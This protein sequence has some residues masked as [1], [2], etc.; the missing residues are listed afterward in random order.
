[1]STLTISMPEGLAK[2][3]R[4]CAAEEGVTVDPLPTPSSLLLA[5][6]AEHGIAARASEA[7]AFR[8]QRQAEALLGVVGTV[9]GGV[10]PPGAI[11]PPEMVVG[12]AA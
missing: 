2:Q 12:L 11:I 1:M 9:H 6:C 7:H 3:L 10:E 8:F 5:P 4:A